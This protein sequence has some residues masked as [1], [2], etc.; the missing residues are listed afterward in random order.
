MCIIFE[1][2]SDIVEV[3]CTINVIISSMRDVKIES[4]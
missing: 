3:P 1:K 4:G 2:L